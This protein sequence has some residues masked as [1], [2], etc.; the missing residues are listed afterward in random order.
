M[1]HKAYVI[2]RSQSALIRKLS[3]EQK[4]LLF[5]AI[6]QYQED[7]TMIDIGDLATEIVFEALRTQFDIDREK[8][9]KRI[10]ANQQNGSNGGRPKKSKNPPKPNKKTENP[11][12][13]NDENWYQIIRSEREENPHN[14]LGLVGYQEKPTESDGLNSKPKK[15]I[16]E[17]DE[18]EDEIE[19]EN[20]I[21]K[22]K[23]VCEW[24]RLSE[25]QIE[26]AK[27]KFGTY[28]NQWLMKL[29][30]YKQS[31]GKR[32]KS[33]YHALI[34]WVYDRFEEQILKEQSWNRDNFTF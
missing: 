20:T 10:K 13:A 30:T 1:E 14:P 31:T 17:E 6:I 8:Y 34:G 33:D 9:D 16:E 4:G 24:V 32:Y 28:Y 22:K 11:Q 15:P 3:R 7:W 29:S 2:Y 21:E 25:K 27:E 12:K 18:I 5:E 23:V 19:K 26:K